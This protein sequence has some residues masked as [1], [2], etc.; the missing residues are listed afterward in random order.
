MR[1][2]LLLLIFALLLCNFIGAQ[3]YTLESKWV[4]CGN[5]VQLLD[6]YYSDGVSF[7]WTGPSKNGKAKDARNKA[8]GRKYSGQTSIPMK[9]SW[10]GTMPN[11]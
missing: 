1:K 3:T 10:H 11:T 6:P 8:T 2:K 5:N 4:N 7:E 9:S